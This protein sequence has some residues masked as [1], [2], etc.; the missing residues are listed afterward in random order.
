M[1]SYVK[2]TARRPAFIH[3]APQAHPELSGSSYVTAGSYQNPQR[4]A[5]GKLEIGRA[6]V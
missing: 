5:F 4:N 6:H 1:P 2:V 3:I